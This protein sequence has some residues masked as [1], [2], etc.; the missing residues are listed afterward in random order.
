MLSE[1]EDNPWEMRE[2]GLWAPDGHRIKIGHFLTT[3]RVAHL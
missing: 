2:F 1:I 3:G